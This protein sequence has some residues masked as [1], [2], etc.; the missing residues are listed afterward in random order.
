MPTESRA[1]GSKVDAERLV[2]LLGQWSS[3]TGALYHQ[4]S[5]ALENLVADGS[6]RADDRLPPERV[7][8]ERLTMSRGTVV[9][10][11]DQLAASGIV[12]RRQGSGTVVEGVDLNLSPLDREFVG[13]PLWSKE[14]GSIDLLKAIPTILPCIE[15]LVASIDLSL[16]GD[17]LNQAEPLGWWRLRESVAALHTRQG[18][19]T[20]GHQILITTGA[21]QAI[22]LV[23]NA[24]V[25]PGDAVI[26]E[27]DSWPGLIDAVRQVGARYEP[28]QMDRDGLVIEDLAVKVERYR[29]SLMVFN[30]QHHNP[31]GTRL[32]A[33][34][35]EAVAAIAREG[36]V[37]I[38][39]DRVAADLGFDRRHLPAIDEFD[40]GGYGLIAGSV[41]KVGWPGLRLG[42][43]R[44][45]AQVINKLR[46]HKAV[47]DMFTPSLSQIIGH[48]IVERYEDVVEA[49]LDQLRPAADLVVDR[50]RRDFPDWTFQAPRGGMSVWARLPGGTSSTAFAAHAARH[51]VAIASGRQFC[52]SDADCPSVR[53]P[54]TIDVDVL[55]EGMRRLAVAWSTFDRAPVQACVI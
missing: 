3:S 13:D 42:W 14:T 15:E 38:L 16:Y 55:G 40:T 51:G 33:D 20:S 23:V 31:T 39:E 8:A 44:A 46:S 2:Q 28:V 29:P 22:S 19:P 54:F 37:P 1:N 26:G 32:P 17:V 30:P 21:Q 24:M 43:L 49:R 35:V 7:L 5:V 12:S 52:P 11:Y 10:A 36:R 4:L 25:R 9:R 27:D 53:I 48:Q 6:L 50:L 47:A 18:L 45:D 41:C 34:R